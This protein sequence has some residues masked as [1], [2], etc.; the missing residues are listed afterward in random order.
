MQDDELVKTRFVEV[1]HL[2]GVVEPLQLTGIGL[3]PADTRV[4]RGEK[5]IRTSK[6][7]CHTRGV[8]STPRVHEVSYKFHTQKINKLGGKLHKCGLRAAREDSVSATAAPHTEVG[9][10]LLAVGASCKRGS[11][12]APPLLVDTLPRTKLAH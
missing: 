11:Y 2:G 9:C 7:G 4:G 12:S 3:G 6:Q 8:L 10:R 5:Q 1:H